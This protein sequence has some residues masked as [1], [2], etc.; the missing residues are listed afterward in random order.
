MRQ[1]RGA[2]FG[3]Y[4]PSHYLS[5]FIPGDDYSGKTEDELTAEAQDAGF[6]DWVTRLNFIKDWQ[7]N[8]D[9][10]TVGPWRTVQPITTDSWVLER[11]PYYWAVDTAGNQLPYIDSIVLTLAENPQ[12]VTLRGIAGELDL[13]ARHILMTELP[14]LIDNQEAGNYTVHLDLA[15]NGADAVFQFNQSFDADPEIAQWLTNTDFRRAMSLGLDRDQMNETFYV[16]TVA[17]IVYVLNCKL[18]TPSCL[19]YR[20]QKW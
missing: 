18:S 1:S 12:I 7:L 11:N 14:A 16:P 17:G 4:A 19:G 20:F 3:A 5:Q 8:I 6:E 2:S 9:V 10:P 15:S 13:Q